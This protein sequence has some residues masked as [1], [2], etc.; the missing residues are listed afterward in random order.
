MTNLPSD[1]ILRCAQDLS[2]VSRDRACPTIQEYV[3]INTEYRAVEVC[4]R[5]KNDLWSFLTFNL[6]DGVELTSLGVGFPIADV[7]EDVIFP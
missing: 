1:V 6:G 7:Y 3:L 2:L 5:E 4:R